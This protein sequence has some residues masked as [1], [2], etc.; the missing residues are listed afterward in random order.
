LRYIICAITSLSA[1]NKPTKYSKLDSE[2]EE[3]AED[4]RDI[5]ETSSAIDIEAISPELNFGSLPP[6]ST[7]VSWKDSNMS[8]N[9][10]TI[11][12]NSGGSVLD[13]FTSTHRL[14]VYFSSFCITDQ[15]TI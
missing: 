5:K 14:T 8:T 3:F 12:F 2:F 11:V 15:Q 9:K 1:R 6:N 13:V 10:D 7:L 4:T